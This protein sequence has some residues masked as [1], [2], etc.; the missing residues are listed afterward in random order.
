[1]GADAR[2][3][4]GLKREG[5]EFVPIDFIP[6]LSG[7]TL[8]DY[9]LRL[10]AVIDRSQPFVVGGVSLGGLMAGEIATALG[11]EKLIL[12]SSLKHSGEMPPHFK[13]A[14]WVPVNKLISG[15]WW[16]EHGPRDNRR[17]LADWQKKILED[18]RHDAD[19]DFITWA[20]DAVL[21]W[22]KARR[23]VHPHLLHL[24]GTRDLMFPGI[25]LGPRIRFA[26]GRHVMVVTHAGE[27]VRE[28]RRFLEAG[29]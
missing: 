7:E 18:I 25:F 11:A 23:D 16:R 9:A 4:E 28:I 26:T 14:R 8:R 21:R 24:H 5:L 1:M 20:M 22:R 27:I 17:G 12:I 29:E 3:F 13:L 10:A 2:L 19:P 15:K 6:A